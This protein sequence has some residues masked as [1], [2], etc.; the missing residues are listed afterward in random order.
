MS[1]ITAW[2]TVSDGLIVEDEVRFSLAELCRACG[3]DSGRISALVAE[4]ILG[5]AGQ[6]PDDWLFSGPA[7][8]TTRTALR[9]ANDLELSPAATALVLELLEEIAALRTRLRRE[10]A[11]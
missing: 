1:S 2:T 10:Q 9:L 7:L 11:P 8:R 4:G 5:P 3:T 6:G